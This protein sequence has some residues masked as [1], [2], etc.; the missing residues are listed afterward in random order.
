MQQSRNGKSESRIFGEIY[1]GKWKQRGKNQ[2]LTFIIFLFFSLLSFPF[3]DP[4]V[5]PWSKKK[6]FR[7]YIKGFWGGFRLFF[8]FGW[9][10]RVSYFSRNSATKEQIHSNLVSFY[11]HFMHLIFFQMCST[12]KFLFGNPCTQIF[13]AYHYC[14]S[15]LRC[16]ATSY[17]QVLH[18]FYSLELQHD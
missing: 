11:L 4:S 5:S 6:N 16:G 13:L 9:D 10:L 1:R 3:I 12:K 2:H 8:P 18:S 7:D 15:N 14:L 17:S